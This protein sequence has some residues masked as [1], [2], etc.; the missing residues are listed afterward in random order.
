MSI[1]VKIWMSQVVGDKSTNLFWDRLRTSSTREG[2]RKSADGVVP[3]IETSTA[4]KYR[5]LFTPSHTR[6]GNTKDSKGCTSDC[7]GKQ[8]FLSVI[9]FPML[10]TVLNKQMLL[11]RKQYS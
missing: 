5:C 1:I 10:S 2:C 4:N 11:R 7:V 6:F 9:T 8:S 3:L